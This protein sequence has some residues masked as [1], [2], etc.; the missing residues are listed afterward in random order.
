VPLAIFCVSIGQ[1]DT[2]A[3]PLSRVSASSLH[4]FTHLLYQPLFFSRNQKASIYESL[5]AVEPG[6]RLVVRYKLLFYVLNL[7]TLFFLFPFF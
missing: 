3:H 4:N 5:G 1:I 7:E 6:G 2:T